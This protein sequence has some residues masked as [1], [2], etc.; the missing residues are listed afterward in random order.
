[1]SENATMEKQNNTE[2]TQIREMYVEQDMT[3]EEIAGKLGMSLGMVYSRL[4]KYD[5]PRRGRGRRRAFEA[6][7]EQLEELYVNQGMSC[8]QIAEKFGVTAS[9]I[10]YRLNRAGV[11]TRSP[12]RPKGSTNSSDSGE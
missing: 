4:R 1:M 7:P 2:A 11:R 5:I 12:G 9:C 3:C 10:L 6:T 8:S